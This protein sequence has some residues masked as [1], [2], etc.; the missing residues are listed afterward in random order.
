MGGV[1]ISFTWAV[2][3]EVDKA[4]SLRGTWPVRRQTYSVWLI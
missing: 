1:L 2:S 3:L 4:Q